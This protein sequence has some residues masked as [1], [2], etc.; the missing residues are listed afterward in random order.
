MRLIPVKVVMVVRLVMSV[1]VMV[2]MV[3]RWWSYCGYKY[4]CGYL[5][6][7]LHSK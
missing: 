3:V 2:V 4:P 1:V 7:A 5:W 6:W